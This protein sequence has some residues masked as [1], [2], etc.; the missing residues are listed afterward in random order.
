MA[1][2]LNVKP[3]VPALNMSGLRED[4]LDTYA[5]EKKEK[6]TG[7]ALYPD[8]FPEKV[9]MVEAL[10]AYR[11]ALG[12]ADDGDSIDT[13]EKNIRKEVLENSLVT[14][15]FRCAQLANGNVHMFLTSGFAV[16]KPA[17]PH[18]KPEKPQDMEAFDGHAEGVIKLE[19]SRTEG[20]V[21]YVIE[22]TE[23]PQ[24]FSSW[25]EVHPMRGGLS[26]KSETL[27]TG[28]TPTRRYWFR[29]TGFNSAGLGETS[30]PATRISQ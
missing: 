5:E 2:P 21:V 8:P 3:I 22:M 26:T 10:N 23:T 14:L 18:A 20:A 12:Q 27:I 16:R 29:V 19:W 9:V 1:E 6:L 17:V 28:L 13:D 30:E 24:N 25:T 7:N 4:A 11:I 15:A